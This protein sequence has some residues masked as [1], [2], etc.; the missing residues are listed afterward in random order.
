VQTRKNFAPVLA[1]IAVAV[2]A[3]VQPAFADGFYEASAAELRGRPGTIIRSEPFAGAPMGAAAYKVLYRS[4]GLKGEPIA[5]SGLMVIPQ[6][7][8]PAGGRP[9]VAWAHGT[10]GVAQKC[11]ASLYP[12]SLT[13]VHGLG[14]MLARGYVVTATD[15]PGLGTA[16]P[17]PYL[18]G[19]SAG[20]A[21]L[22]SVRLQGVRWLHE[23]DQPH[24]SHQRHDYR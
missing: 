1:A 2:C 8:V 13:W 6:G 4:T 20:R 3:L 5:V 7:P 22:D 19:E 11:G 10:I 18:I 15:Y 12:Q 24:D 16:G 17:H 21:V 14:D 9:V 23:P